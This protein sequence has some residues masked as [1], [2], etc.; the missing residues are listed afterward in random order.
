MKTYYKSSEH[1]VRFDSES[2][3]LLNIFKNI[4]VVSMQ[5]I[6]QS[7][8]PFMVNSLSSINMPIEESEFDVVLNLA[9]EK[10]NSL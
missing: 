10:I 5:V 9:K 8:V 4:D 6:E 2:G 1:Y 3:E 7:Q